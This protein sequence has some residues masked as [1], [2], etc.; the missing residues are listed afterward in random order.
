[1]PL[2]GASQ[3]LTDYLVSVRKSANWV[4]IKVPQKITAGI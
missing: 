3:A 1:M 2:P 4:E